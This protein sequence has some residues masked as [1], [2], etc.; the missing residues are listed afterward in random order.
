GKGKNS[1]AVGLHNVA[2]G[3]IA[4]GSHDAV[5]GGQINSIGESIAKFLGGEASFKDGGLTQPTYKLSDVSTEGKVTDKTFT[6][7]GSAF[8][9]LD[10][11]IKNV[12]DRIKEVSEGVAQDS[13]NWS[14]TEGAFVAQHGKEGAKANSKIKFL[15]AG[16]V[17]QASTEAVN[18]S[19]LYALGSSVA[20]YFGGGAGYDKEGNLKAPSFK[21]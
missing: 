15:A 20:Q 19:Q 7:V 3:Q 5:T 4:N 2:D 11:N 12:N 21:V 14:N 17:G 10:K 13:L 18:G 8:T 9:G 6:D 1:T 16:D